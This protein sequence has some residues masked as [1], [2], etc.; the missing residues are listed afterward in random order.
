MEI[1]DPFGDMM[2]HRAPGAG[3]SK[4]CIGGPAK[5]AGAPRY[6]C[7]VFVRGRSHEKDMRVSAFMPLKGAARHEDPISLVNLFRMVLFLPQGENLEV[8]HGL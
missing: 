1:F 5:E 2:P 8:I 4:A 7:R 6:Q 3:R